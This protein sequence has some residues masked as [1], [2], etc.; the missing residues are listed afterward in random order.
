MRSYCTQPVSVH[1]M[2]KQD[3]NIII[4]GV[5]GQGIITLLRIA[6][7]AALAQEYDVRTS[8]LHGL[9][10]KGGTVQAHVRFGKKIFS[11]L[12]SKGQADLVLALEAVEA[13]RALE[14]AGSGTT[15]LVNKKYI[16]F[17][18]AP[19]K[20]KVF[21]KLNSLSRRINWVEA[22]D[23]CAKELGKEVLA[24]VYL[25]FWAALKG[26]IPL[27][28]KSLLKGLKKGLRPEYLDL[29]KQ[30]FKLVQDN[31]L[32]MACRTPVRQT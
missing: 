25:L 28:E 19:D 2:K 15:L 12:V 17:K 5:G 3:F 30:V 29:N 27:Q 20:D 4:T 24:G 26:I 22:S 6:A 10:Q 31:V 9:S 16:A 7:E 14:F 18:G 32:I 8:E 13:L 1:K 23:I 11:P 21:Q